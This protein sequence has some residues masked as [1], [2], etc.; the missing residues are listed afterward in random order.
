[1]TESGRRAA[2]ATAINPALGVEAGLAQTAYLPFRVFYQTPSRYRLGLPA[3][4]RA[5][6]A[7]LIRSFEYLS[8]N[9]HP[10]I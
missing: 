8:M 4:P 7:R 6:I 5:L 9:D 10:F 3:A 1:V 2:S